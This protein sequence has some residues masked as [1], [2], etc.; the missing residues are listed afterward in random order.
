LLKFKALLGTLTPDEAARWQAICSIYTRRQELSGADDPASKAVVQLAKLGDHLGT[1]HAAILDAA[2]ATQER[3]VEERRHQAERLELLVDRLATTLTTLKP[4]PAP[5]MQP[6]FEIINTIPK[7]YANLYA[8]QI[9]VI[10]KTLIPAIEAIGAVIGQS[11]SAREH[12]GGIANDLRAMIAKQAKSN[13]I[14]S[15]DS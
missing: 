12:L 2:T 14:E 8:Q 3:T 5:A 11:L 13:V 15:K 1:L 6:K 4:D 9:Q 10:E 7:Y